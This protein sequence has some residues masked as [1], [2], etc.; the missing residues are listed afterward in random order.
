MLGSIYAVWLIYAAGLSYML[1]A[2]VLIALGLPVYLWTRKENNSP[3]LTGK[4][5]ILISIILLLSVI[6]IYCFIRGIISI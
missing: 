4:E 2:V 1:M 6:A 3:S 5:K